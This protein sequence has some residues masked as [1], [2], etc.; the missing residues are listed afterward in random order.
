LV[1]QNGDRL[2]KN[3]YANLRKKVSAG[4]ATDQFMF[5]GQCLVDDQWMSKKAYFS[6]LERIKQYYAN[7][8]LVYVKHPRESK[9]ILDQIRTELNFRIVSFEVPIEFELVKEG[10]PKEM[11]SFFCSAIEN[12][13]IIFGSSLT[14]TAFYIESRDLLCCQDFAKQMYAY[15]KLKENGHFRVIAV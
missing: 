8:E 7:E 3:V 10:V 1:P 4:A 12:C 6:Y 15:W 9:S 2:I 11:A 13:R 5:I 14:I